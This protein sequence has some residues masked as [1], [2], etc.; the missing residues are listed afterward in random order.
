MAALMI[1][2]NLPD[3]DV[4]AI[5]FGESLTFRRGWTHGPLAMAV[6]PVLL[7][8]LLVAWDRRQTRRGTRPAGRPPVRPAQLFALSL[9]GVVSHPAL[10]WLN[11]YGIRLLMPFSERWFYGDTIF[12][13]DPWIWMA[14][15]IGVYLSRRRIRLRR[16]PATGPARVAVATVVGYVLLMLVGSRV[17]H[18]VATRHALEAQDL[19]PRRVMAG[20]VPLN[21]L[22]RELVYDFGEFYRF[23]SLTWFPDRRITLEGEDLPTNVDHPLV[24][25]AV[26]D[27]DVQD[28]LYWSRFPF[29]TVEG[30]GEVALVR[31]GD[32]RFARRP[33]GWASV[34]VRV[35][36]G[37]A[38]VGR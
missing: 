29:F 34:E 16:G 7:T 18:Q 9:I 22:R 23:G 13:I 17:A 36:T 2:A 30:T 31:V 25:A 32:V 37:G 15:G 10:D 33:G 21:P 11:T 20:P 26:R 19:V 6:L 14:L 1:G 38:G 24:R 3:L 27:P 8:A 12:I 28:F 35:P 5:P 4:A